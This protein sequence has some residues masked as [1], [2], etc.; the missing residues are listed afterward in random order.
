MVFA[1]KSILV[2]MAI[3]FL[4]P[5]CA[6]SPW[7][8]NLER[9]LAG[10]PSLENG[11]VFGTPGST[12]A[13][14]ND[15][16]TALPAD[17][18]AEIPR[19]TNAELLSVTQA[20][21]ADL[22]SGATGVTRTRWATP[23]PAEEIAQFYRDAFNR[24]GWQ[25]DRS[26]EEP[27]NTTTPAPTASPNASTTVA[28]SSA[29]SI[30]APIVAERDG[31][32]V[33][34]AIDPD[35]NS[36]ETT[37]ENTTEFTI[38]YQFIN[39][40]TTAQVSPAE[41]GEGT[42]VPNEQTQRG[43]NNRSASGSPSSTLTAPEFTDLNQAPTELQPYIA[44]L[45]K[46]GAL[47]VQA[48]GSTTEFSP[49]TTITRREYARWLVTANNLIYANQPARRIRLGVSSDQPAFQD[50]PVSD[51]DFGE[52]QGLANAGLI[53]SSLSGDATAVTFRPDAPLTREEL[54]LWKVPVDLRKALPNATIEAV[55][56]TWGFQDTAQ[57]DPR[58]LRA[59]LADFQ[60]SDLSN[61]RRAF[62][63]TTLFQ[64][65]KPVT[66]AEAAAVLWF[67]GS[68][69]DGLSARDVLQPGQQ[70]G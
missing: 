12:A 55:Q 45:A 36:T 61:I 24:D 51:P 13:A 50:V 25:L 4:L 44:D 54:M 21:V 56:Q 52:I 39:N 20:E 41:S 17:F 1:K 59:I 28:G 10:D 33:T 8:S 32:R 53:P 68:Q 11:S 19:Y 43:E 62:G 66:R 35:V 48:T 47:R 67:F 7:A 29:T 2:L 6:N 58:A 57:I 64:P 27:N 49:N 3:G 5:A 14:E 26:S 63:Y 30:S 38:D 40:Q 37:A 69:G 60:N 34:V 16:V 22:S 70:G 18:P 9:S 46:L 65:D 15:A 23:D 42:S 31:L